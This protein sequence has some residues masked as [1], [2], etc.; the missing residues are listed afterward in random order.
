MSQ[1]TQTPPMT[2]HDVLA[3][4]IYLPAFLE[5]CS[6]RGVVPKNEDEVGALLTVAQNIRLF[7]VK[8]AAAGVPAGV[9]SQIEKAAAASTAMLGVPEADPSPFLQDPA[10]IAAFEVGGVPA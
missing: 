1:E 2:V 8:Q 10:V 6:S 7:E 5:K 9:P 4:R 3:S